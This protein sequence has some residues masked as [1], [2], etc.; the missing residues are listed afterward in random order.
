MQLPTATGNVTLPRR[1]KPIP[2]EVLVDYLTRLATAN[3][4]NESRLR[5]LLNCRGKSI[6]A[7][8]RTAVP[9]SDRAIVFALPELR[10]ADDLTTYPELRAC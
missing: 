5:A 10:G 7:G 6:R 2:N 3:G 8:L 9:M 4:I 1:V